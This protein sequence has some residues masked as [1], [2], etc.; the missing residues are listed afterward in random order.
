MQD[1][2]VGVLGTGNMGESMINGFLKSQIVSKENI[3]AFDFRESR[4]YEL[5]EELGIHASNSNKEVVAES[6]LIFIAVKPQDLGELLDEI[7]EVTLRD[8][9]FISLAAGISIDFIKQ[10]LG[11]NTKIIR[12]MPNT[13]CLIGSGVIAM[14]EDGRNKS[15]DIKL[16]KSLLAPTAEVIE[17]KEELM[18]A[19][20]GLSGNGPA[21]AFLMME[22]LANGGIKM[23]L[24]KDQSITMAAQVMQ[25]AAKMVL[26]TGKHPAELKEMVSSPGGTAI[27]SLQILEDNSVRG[28]LMR[29]VEAGANRAKEISEAAGNKK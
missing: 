18:N 10:K 24:A 26:E 2:I 11:Y 7:V 19:V 3:L 25:G 27:H 28:S 12:L 1:K 22:A 29:A 4:L 6:D 5:Q 8:K 17:V 21:Y 13:P 9:I 15:E 16:V 14:A 20:T 23:G